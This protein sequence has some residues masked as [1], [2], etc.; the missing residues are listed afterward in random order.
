M[1][2]LTILHVILYNLYRIKER[3]LYMIKINLE[4]QE[5]VGVS[6]QVEKVNES[7]E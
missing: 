2:L 7:V 4:N 6:S 3:R 1:C 5:L